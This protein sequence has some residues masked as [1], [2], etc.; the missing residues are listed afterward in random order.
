VSKIKILEKLSPLEA[1][2]LH[3]IPSFN[4]IKYFF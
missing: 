4:E 3:F 2:L 1:C